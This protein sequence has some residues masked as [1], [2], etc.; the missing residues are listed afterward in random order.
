MA[1]TRGGIVKRSVSKASKI[2][3][4]KAKKVPGLQK[5]KKNCS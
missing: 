4:R 5:R 2:K 3:K 1:K